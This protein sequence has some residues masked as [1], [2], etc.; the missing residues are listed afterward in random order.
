MASRRLVFQHFPLPVSHFIHPLQLP[1]IV[2]PF[3][4]PS[5]LLTI[6]R[7]LLFFI[8]GSVGALVISY[9]VLCR[10]LIFAFIF[11]VTCEKGTK[12]TAYICEF[13]RQGASTGCHVLWPK[14]NMSEYIYIYTMFF[15]YTSIQIHFFSSRARAD[16]VNEVGQH[17]RR[18]ASLL[19]CLLLPYHLPPTTT[20][21]SF[22]GIILCCRLIHIWRLV[23]YAQCLPF[24]RLCPC[25]RRHTALMPFKRNTTRITPLSPSTHTHTPTHGDTL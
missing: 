22:R 21:H 16:K 25:Q 12:I 18:Q 23:K 17:Y 7:N 4:C 13:R 1:Y 15:I 24:C 8:L 2:R 20:W 3:V 11:H 9:R 19:L 6:Y 14:V 10:L 5:V